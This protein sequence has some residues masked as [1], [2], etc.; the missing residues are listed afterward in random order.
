[1]KKI[2]TFLIAFLA[3]A[4]FA[5]APVFACGKTCGAKT[6][7]ASATGTDVKVQNASVTTSAKTCSARASLASSKSSCSAK[8]TGTSVQTASVKTA[9]A[10]TVSAKSAKT[11]SVSSRTCSYKASTTTAQTTSTDASLTSQKLACS[12][13]TYA[14]CKAFMSDEDCK[15]LCGKYEFTRISIAGM[16]CGGCE[17]AVTAALEKTEGVI[18]VLKVDYEKGVAI[19]A[20]D[21][22][23]ATNANLTKA[24]ADKGFKAEIIVAVAKVDETQENKE[25]STNQ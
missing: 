23:K 10:K 2:L 1:M 6:S 22:K 7:N 5:S 24:V 4:A 25:V 8:A 16:T 12:V 3:V 17:G 19:V 15:N 9:S 18:K 21:T 20:V 11:C 13:G 14:H